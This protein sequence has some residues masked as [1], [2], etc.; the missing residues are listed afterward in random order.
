LSSVAYT[1]PFRSTVLVTWPAARSVNIK[2]IMLFGLGTRT[3]EP[4]DGKHQCKGTESF[5]EI[6]DLHVSV[7]VESTRFWPSDKCSLSPSDSFL[8]ILIFFLFLFVFSSPND[9][10][11]DLSMDSQC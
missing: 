3:H 11:P 6:H 10:V 5:Y 1:I 2:M 9:F 4:Y 7:L 8:P